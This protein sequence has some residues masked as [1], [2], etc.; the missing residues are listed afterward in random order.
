MYSALWKK[1][2]EL[3]M[4]SGWLIMLLMNAVLGRG[5]TGGHHIII[6]VT[7]CMIIFVR[8]AYSS[9]K[10]EAFGTV[11]FLTLILLGIDA[12]RSLP[13]L[14]SNPGIPRLLMRDIDPLLRFESSSAGVGGYNL[15]TAT[16]IAFPVFIA[17]A[18]S[19]SGIKRPIL[20][21]SCSCIGL[22]VILSTFTSA[23]SIML[24][25]IIVFVLLAYEKSLKKLLTSAVSLVLVL[26]II[27]A[28]LSF[29]GNTEQVSFV[30][31]KIVRLYEGITESGVVRGDETGRGSLFMLSLNTFMNNLLIGVGPCTT[32]LNPWLYTYVGGHSSWID[33]LAEYGIL[34]FGWFIIFAL[35][36]TVQVVRYFIRYKKNLI[37]RAA[38][39]SCILYFIGGVVNPVLFVN[40]ISALFYLFVL[41]SME[42]TVRNRK[43]QV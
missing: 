3:L 41:G 32:V 24:L 5:Y 37:V 15:Y 39:V 23:V 40:S 6:M 31:S 4:F 20:L 16:A 28:V 34:G 35:S 43:V 22:A 36:G 26:L 11:A 17:V 33:Q 42:S 1:R 14:F 12:A 21:I 18:F 25:G 29:L 2:F 10:P 9:L 8:I 30:T 7:L 19:F 13:T 27:F 38:F